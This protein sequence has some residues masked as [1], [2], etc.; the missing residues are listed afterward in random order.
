VASQPQPQRL[1][2]IA[3]GFACLI[4]ALALSG[5]I[6]G[7][8]VLKSIVPGT[9]TM[10]P[11]TAI[12]FLAFGGALVVV[13]RGPGLRWLRLADGLAL[14]ALLL[15]AVVGSQYVLNANFGI[16]ELLFREP[17]GAVGTINPGRMSP[18]TALSFVILGAA[19]LAGRRGAQGRVVN[20]LVSIPALLGTLNGLDALFGAATPSFLAAYTQMALPTAAGLAALSVGVMTLLPGDTPLDHFRG[21]SHTSVFAR[22]LLLAA[23]TVPIGV[24]WL[25][26]EGE[27]LGLFD[28]AFG[29]SMTTFSTVCLLL[30]VIVRATK[31]LEVSDARRAA[32]EAEAREA[33]RAADVANRAKTEFLSRMSHELRTPLNAIL[34][35]AQLLEMD[36]L[37]PEQRENVR[38][39][40]RGGEQLLSLVNEVLDISRIESGALS[41]SPEPVWLPEVL[42]EQQALMAPMAAERHITIATRASPAATGHVLAD[43]QRLKQVLLNLLSNA[44]KYNRQGGRVWIECRE[45]S[46]GRLRIDVTDTGF[47]IPPDKLDRLFTPFDRLGAEQSGVEGTGIGL[48]LTRRL[49]EEMGGSLAVESVLGEGSTFSVELASVEDPM[50]RLAT[51]EPV[52][53]AAK[54]SPGARVKTVLHIEDNLSNL[55]LVEQLVLQRPE[56]RLI[57]AIQGRL[58]LELAREHQPGLILLDLHL[59]DMKGVEVLAE[60]RRDPQ[61]RDIPVTI[62]SAD[63]TVG[64]VE[65]LKEAGARGHMAKPLDVEAFLALIDATPGPAADIE[66]IG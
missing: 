10:K 21:T 42:E 37:E 13:A 58:G 30:V 34:G 31:T 27:R 8:D 7:I 28:T 59:P 4:G 3:G 19:F 32:S 48:T 1:A 12:A 57:T 43:R 40:R 47:G 5:W 63:A 2:L 23:L 9:I 45:P 52:V 17:T 20:I 66:A 44:V 62:V 25:H 6:L 53:A 33:R 39:I 41:L 56:V 55:R 60:L 24:A 65:R 49:V 36:D 54:R 14:T 26:L 22:R 29:V 15:G 11:N 64:L 61:T 50:G 38:Y 51:I 46:P 35:F 18:Q 16:D